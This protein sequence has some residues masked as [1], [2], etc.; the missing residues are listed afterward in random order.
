[1]ESRC[2]FLATLAAS[3]VAFTASRTLVVNSV[4]R[5]L[6]CSVKEASN[7]SEDWVVVAATTAGVAVVGT[8]ISA[9]AGVSFLGALVAFFAGAAAGAGAGAGGAD[10][11][12]VFLSAGIVFDLT[13]EV[14]AG[15][16]NALVYSLP[17]AGM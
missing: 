15:I 1:L 12:A 4:E 11:A 17:A 6:S 5:A 2:S 9:L 10:L 3:W 14:E 7:A 13:A 8:T 16:S